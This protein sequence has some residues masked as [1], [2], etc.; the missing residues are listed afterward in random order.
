VRSNK[1]AGFSGIG[2]CYASLGSSEAILGN[3]YNEVDTLVMQGLAFKFDQSATAGRALAGIG[4]DFDIP[5]LAAISNRSL[6]VAAE[7][8]DIARVS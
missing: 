3:T 2:T 5:V 8:D 1:L 7:G 4:F 6:F